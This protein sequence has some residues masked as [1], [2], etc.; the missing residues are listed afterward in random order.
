MTD[1]RDEWIGLARVTGAV[2]LFRVVA[3]CVPI[4]AVTSR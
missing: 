4:I 1:A 2:G 3:L